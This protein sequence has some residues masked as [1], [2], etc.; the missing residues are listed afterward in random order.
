MPLFPYEIPAEK[1]ELVMKAGQAGWTMNA[2][3]LEEARKLYDD[4]ANAYPHR[5][6]TSITHT[7][8]CLRFSIR[9]K[10]SSSFGKNW[11]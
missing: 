6:A 5:T 7:D 10:R 2:H 1:N 8:I 9:R 11:S 3:H 4:L